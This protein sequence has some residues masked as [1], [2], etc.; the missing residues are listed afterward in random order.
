[1]KRNFNAGAIRNLAFVCLSLVSALVMAE[2][3]TKPVEFTLAAGTV[4]R[5]NAPVRV[6]LNLPDTV[7]S[8]TVTAEDGKTFSADVVA[9]SLLSG[10]AAGQRELVFILPSLKS[11][12]SANFKATFSTAAGEG[13]KWVET[14]GDNI[15]LS[16]KDRK[17]LRYWCK[18]YDDSTPAKQNETYKVFHQMYD[19]AGERLVN[20]GPGG[21][22]THHRGI[23]YGFNKVSYGTTNC[24]IWHCSKGTHQAH[25]KVVQTEAGAVVGRQLLLINWVG[26]E[27]TPFAEELRELTIFNTVGGTM[28]EF[29]SRVSSKVGTIKVGGD[30]QHAGFHFRAHLDVEE[31]TESETYYIRPDGVGKKAADQ[32]EPKPGKDGK[33]PARQAETRNW[34]AK[35][36]DKTVNLPWNAM[37][38]VI[39]GKRY[40]AGYLD[41]TTNPKE[42]R[43]SERTYGRFGSYFETEFDNAK[44]LEVRYRIWLQEAAASVEVLA[45]KDAD[46]VTPVTATV[47]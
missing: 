2:N 40:T 5:E 30:P 18:T 24:D 27:K 43:C 3:E 37:S 35:N 26:P 41:H 14:Q 1:M 9:P 8:A 45:A 17:V 39:E 12:Q 20:K 34:S 4:D 16:F 7:R 38:F 13:F 33:T 10:A 36:P 23:F 28:L 29:Q 22:F 15:E 32:P 6:L 11:G 25:V 46:F 19:P 42:A 47:K 31:K 21:K 44:P